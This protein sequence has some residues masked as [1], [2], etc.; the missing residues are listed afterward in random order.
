MSILPEWERLDDAV[1][2]AREKLG[3]ASP[4]EFENVAREL[5][6]VRGLFD[7][8]EIVDVAK[9]FPNFD[10][11]RAKKV[12]EEWA[13]ADIGEVVTFAS[14]L[15]LAAG[16]VAVLRMIERLLHEPG[17]RL[18]AMRTDRLAN[19]IDKG[20]VQSKKT[21]NA[22]RSTFNGQCGKVDSEFNVEC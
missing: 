3:K 13:D 14:D 4:R 1:T 16:I 5:A 10:E 15:G 7:N 18:R 20:G 12:P 11:L 9:P 22:L 6:V 21:F 19:K 2:Y 17:E 8:E